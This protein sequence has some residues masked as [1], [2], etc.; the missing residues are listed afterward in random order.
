[1]SELH[2]PPDNL[3]QFYENRLD[4]GQKTQADHSKWLINTL[5]LLHSGA[6]AGIISRLPIEKISQFAS[7]LTWFAVGLAF[8]FLAGL[9]TWSN[10]DLFNRT[11]LE[12]I[13]RIRLNEWRSG[14]IPNI[15]KWVGVTAWLALALGLA[16]FGCLLIGACSALSALRAV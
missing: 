2:K 14:E 8:A 12:L 4:F 16:S 15:A 5:Y 13:R 11:Y 6:I 1:M 3:L 7:C 10:Y 9:A